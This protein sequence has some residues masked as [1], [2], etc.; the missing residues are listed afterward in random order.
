[1]STYEQNADDYGEDLSPPERIN[2]PIIAAFVSLVVP[3][4][5]QYYN[6]YFLRG[7]AVTLAFSLATLT[8]G[9][10][11]Y[12]VMVAGAVEALMVALY[13]QGQRTP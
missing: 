11:G 7:I 3:G 1:M 8:V 9:P 4:G 12:L 5:G 2:F 13:D 10:F 6:R